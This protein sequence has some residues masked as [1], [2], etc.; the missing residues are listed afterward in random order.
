MVMIKLLKE[1]KKLLATQKYLTLKHYLISFQNLL[2]LA[3]RMILLLS[4]P[5]LRELLTV[6]PMKSIGHI[7]LHLTVYNFKS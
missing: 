5:W 1:V 2:A 7:D 3:L 4:R 6:F